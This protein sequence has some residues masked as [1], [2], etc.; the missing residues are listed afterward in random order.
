MRILRTLAATLAVS[1][2]LL[3]AGATSVLA[4]ADTGTA[5]YTFADEW[6]FDHGTTVDCSV[7]RGTLSV[8]AT[9]DGREVVRIQHRIAVT[10]YDTDGAVVGQSRERSLSRTVYVDGGQVSTFTIEHGRA[11]GPGYDCVYGYQ[12]KVV[13][14]ELVSERYTGPGCA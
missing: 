6:C 12:L 10:T 13:D 2:I 7:T 8:T 9:P 5:R 4:A 3:G 1:A 14:F 11:T